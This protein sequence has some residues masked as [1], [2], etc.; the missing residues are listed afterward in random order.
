MHYVPTMYNSLKIKYVTNDSHNI[1]HVHEV[2]L[3]GTVTVVRFSGSY[4]H[5]FR[6]PVAMLL[7][8]AESTYYAS[9]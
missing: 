3:H 9:S 7:N 1:I 8:V 2:A 4:V 5:S 6:S